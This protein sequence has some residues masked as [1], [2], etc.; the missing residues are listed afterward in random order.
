MAVVAASRGSGESK[1]VSKG[2]KKRGTGRGD[3]GQRA[4]YIF[5]ETGR[6]GREG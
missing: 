1:G 2:M 5:N 6:A 4:L 3:R